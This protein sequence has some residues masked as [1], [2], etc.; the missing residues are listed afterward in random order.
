MVKT[1]SYEI[2]FDL[3]KRSILY[4]LGILQIKSNPADIGMS[5]MPFTLQR[6]SIKNILKSS[7]VIIEK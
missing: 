7:S 3:R 1:V 4:Y 6:I 2:L 5:F